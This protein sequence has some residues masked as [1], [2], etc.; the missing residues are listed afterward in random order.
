MTKSGTSLKEYEKALISLKEALLIF[1]NEK[2]LEM[3][4]LIRDACI[5]RFEFCVKLAWK[6]SLK[7]IGIQAL[8]PKP[9]IR[10]MAQGELIENIDLWFDFIEA[11]NKSSHT[12]DENVA[13]QVFAVALQFVSEGEALLKKLRNK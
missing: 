5:Q 7:V 2:E 13:Q 3:Q 11:R 6:S 1:E 10:E 4:K 9:A 12:Y 8:P